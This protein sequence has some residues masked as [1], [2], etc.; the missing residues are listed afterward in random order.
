MRSW[1]LRSLPIVTVAALCCAVSGAALA[2]SFSTSTLDFNGLGGVSSGTSLMFGPDGRL[3]VAQ[4]DG[5]LDV[6][7][8][9]RQGVDDYVVVEAEEILDVKNIPNHNDDGGANSG[10]SREMTGITVAGSAT[11]PV[12]YATSSDSRIGGPSGDTDLDT[13]SGVITRL[14]WQGSDVDDPSGFWEVVDIVRGLSRSEENHATN[15]LEHAAIGG[16]DYLIVSSGGHTNAGSPSTNFAWHTEYALSAAVLAVDLGQL[17]ALPILNDGGRQY[18]YDLPTLDDPTRANVN[19][20]TDPNAGGYDGIDVADPWGGNDGLNQGKLVAGGPVQIFSP[21]YRNSYDL[22]VTQSGAVYVTDN[23]ANG[24]WGG[25]PENEGIAGNTTNNYRVGEPG[26]TGSDPVDGEAQ[27]NNQ[28]H[29]SL[30]T[31]DLQNYTFGSFYGGHPAPVRAN[32]AGAGL[33][34]RGTHSSD[35]GDSNGNGYTDD[36]FR[37]VPY[38]PNGVGEAADA[39]QALPADWPPVPLGLA[40]AVQGDFRNPGGS[41]P[42]GPVDAIVT[43][44][45]N[46]SNGIDEYTAS[47]FAGAM[48]GDLIA[49][50][51]GGNLHRVELNPDGSLAQLHQNWVSG[52]GGNALGVTANGDSDPFPGTIWVATLNSDV[53][54]LEPQDFVICILPG[55]PG[56][57][58]NADN[59]SD[60]Y[61][62]QDEVD[63]ATDLCNGGSQPGDHDKAAGAPLVSDLNDLNDDAD[64][65]NDAVDVLQLGDPVDAGSDAF[66]LPVIN[67]LFSDNPLLGGYLGLGFP[68]LMNNGAPNPNWL[69]WL[70][71]IDA[72]PNPNDI[73]GGAVGAMTMQMTEGTALGAT[74]TQEKGFQ[75]G[76]DVDLATGGFKVRA[77]MLNF[78]AGLQLY[79]FAGD[80]KLG[81]FLGDGTQSNYIRFI[82]DKNGVEVLQEI[83]DVPQAPFSAPIAVIDRPS[84][85]IEFELA[86]DSATGD[87]EAFYGI[88][89]GALTSVGTLTAQGSILQAIQQAGVPLIVG[90]IGT[91]NTVGAEVEGTWDYLNVAGQRPT[92]EQPLPNVTVSVGGP[93]SQDIDLDTYF[94]DDEGDG[95]LTYSIE[96]ETNTDI[97]TSINGNLLS[98]SFPAF[99]ASSTITVRATDS[100]SLFVEQAFTVSTVDPVAIY[101]VNAGGA[102][103]TAIDGGIDWEEDTTGNNSAYLTNPGGN[104]A[105]GFNITTFTPEVDQSTTP[106]SIYQTERWSSAPG[107]PSMTYAFPIAQAGN[108]EVRLYMGNGWSGAS[109]PGQRVFSVTIEGVAYP[110]LTDLDLTATFG[111]EV[112]GVVS[113]LVDVTDGLLEIDFTH[114]SANNPLVNGIEI[115]AG[116]GGPV[117]NPISVTPIPDQLNDEGDLVNLPVI[118]NGGDTP[119]NFS[120]SGTGLPEGLQIEPTTGLI[121]GTLSVGAAASSPHAV[122]VTVDD[123]DGETTDEVTVAFSWTVI[124]P[125]AP[126]WI[127]LNEDETY[128]ARHE[129]SF[130]QAGDKFYLFGGRENAQTLETYD[131]TSDSWT[132]SASVPVEFNHFQALEYEGLVWVIG[133]FQTNNFPNEVPAESIYV[134]DPALDLW[135]QGPAVPIARQRGSAGLVVHDGKFYVVGGNTDGHDGGYVDWFDE[136]DPETGTWTQLPAAP[137]ARDHFHAAVVGDKLYALGG[138]LSGGAGGTFAPLIPEVDVYDFIAGTWST[139]PLASDLPTPRAASAVAVFDGEIL[140]IGGEGGGQAYDT[141]EALDPLTDSWRTLASLNYPRHGTQAIVSGPFLIPAGG[142]HD[143]FVR[144]TGTNESATATLVVG[145]GGGQTVNVEL[146]GILVAVPVGPAVPWLLPALLG[147]LGSARLKRRC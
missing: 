17:G 91:S 74:N 42:D 103:T 128:T 147:V 63:N 110:D 125:L 104:S 102:Q 12:V 94:D 78:A 111:H 145:Y 69:N 83:V 14:A 30:V 22:V 53:V 122:S 134:Y 90:L 88:D 6:F 130:V 34:T 62:N 9:Q 133:A 56:Y 29:L 43:T 57:D 26:S 107:S 52:I 59:D 18:I 28:D 49:G 39:S 115:I 11:N 4:V 7:T 113:H 73:L 112:G 5:T 136:Y 100:D 121:F 86:V 50:R 97:G 20:I 143:V 45:Q 15:G 3:Y 47:N 46:N 126:V 117:Q 106:V 54:I 16:T 141:V 51:S 19:G 146:T 93:A 2:Q 99:V 80:G 118:A 61:S 127:D 31:T 77:R 13:N 105:A 131:F 10:S 67:E 139:L 101:R 138:R 41:N 27:V 123:L 36:W 108:H 24:G 82:V 1:Q 129:C 75:Y 84:S 120:F 66:S 116:A 140:V 87:V 85:S 144:Y 44:W 70:D 64:A 48:Q 79:P 114:G 35:P 60:G 72:G 23:G 132:I 37:T 119:G 8:V 135:M 109:S 124:D 76:V 89:G 32:P 142:I 95:N 137:H 38:D 71:Q 25:F 55:E 96:A 33:F 98:L 58:P 68:G 40:D 81:I 92:V 21:G 65:A